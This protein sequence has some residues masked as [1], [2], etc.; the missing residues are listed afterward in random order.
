MQ[1]GSYALTFTALSGI[2]RFQRQLPSRCRILRRADDR[3]Q[4]EDLQPESI[5]A[6]QCE[7]T[8]KAT[9]QSAFSGNDGFFTITGLPSG[10]QELIVMGEKPIWVSLPSWPCR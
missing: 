4:R 10:K 9:G 3:S 7:V 8:L 5:A 1:V 2:S 6:G